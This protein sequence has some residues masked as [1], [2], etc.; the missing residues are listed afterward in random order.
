MV[1]AFGSWTGQYVSESIVEGVGATAAGSIE[2]LLSRNLEGVLA[3]GRV[4]EANQ[5]AID[6]AVD[7]ASSTDTTRLLMLRLRGADGTL[8]LQAGN[9]LEDIAVPTV[10]LP[11]EGDMTIAFTDVTLPPLGGLPRSKLPVLKIYAAVSDRSGQRGS[12]EMYLSA[13]SLQGLQSEATTAAWIIAAIVGFT[14]LGL[15]AVL[16]D[17]TDTII[18]AQR[19]ALA[20]NLRQ[21]QQLLRENV[22]LRRVSEGMRTDSLLANERVLAEVGSDIHDGPVQLLT[23]LILKLPAGPASGTPSNRDLA[24]QAMEELRGIS[25]GLVLPE[26]VE[27]SLPDVIQSAIVRHENLTGTI[28]TRRID[29]AADIHSQLTARIGAFRVLQEALNNAHRHG[30]GNEAQVEA[31]AMGGWLHLV[32]ANRAPEDASIGYPPDRLGL[33]SMRFRVESQGGRLLVASQDGHVRVEAW[34]PLTLASATLPFIP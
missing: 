3:D 1:V 26:I 21:T 22:T 8:L 24:Q 9:E 17:A 16:V 29:L 28:V 23:L 12:V 2:A 34:M 33:R 10:D 5:A 15:V 19:R 4:T 18:S 27:M 13:R 30:S 25:A 11:V 6:A 32:V 7:I 31:S 20:R 14:A